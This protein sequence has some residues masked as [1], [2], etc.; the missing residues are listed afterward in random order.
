MEVEEWVVHSSVEPSNAVNAPADTHPPA[1][2]V[3]DEARKRAADDK[4]RES[5]LLELIKGPIRPFKE[6]S[7]REAAYF[8]ELREAE[9]VEESC[10][11]AKLEMRVEDTSMQSSENR[12]IP[13]T[14]TK[15]PLTQGRVPTALSCEAVRSVLS[16]SQSSRPSAID[17]SLHVLTPLL[18]N[19]TIPITRQGPEHFC[20]DAQESVASLCIIMVGLPARGKTFLAQRICR[21]LGWHGYRA[22]V[23]NIQVAWRR[24]LLEYKRCHSGYDAT[25]MLPVDDASFSAGFPPAKSE[26][27]P[28]QSKTPAC[29]NSGRD[30]G[31]T[32]EQNDISDTVVSSSP[33]PSLPMMGPSPKRDYVCAEQFRALICDP[34]SI[35]RR[36][37]RRVLERYALDAKSFYARGGDVLVVNDD[38]ITEELRDEAEALFSPLASQTFFMEVI[39]SNERNQKF[40]E[41]KL[42]DKS[43]YPHDVNA[44]EAQRDFARR[45]EYLTEVY[46]T[47]SSTSQSTGGPSEDEGTWGDVS[48]AKDKVSEK[49]TR[50]K[51]RE[52]R[53]MKLW[54]SVEIEVHG[55]TGYTASRIVSY[56]MNLTQDKIQHPIFFV[57]HGESIYNVENR[58][59]GDSVLSADGEKGANEI[60]GF[61]ASLKR[62]YCADTNKT[63]DGEGHVNNDDD[64]AGGFCSSDY[65]ARCEKSVNVEVWTSQLRRA[66][67][68]VENSELLLGIKNVRWSSLNE[69]H[70]GI[71]EDLTFE[72]VRTQHPLI[73]QFRKIN[74]Y[75]FR[76]P[77]GESYQDLVLRLEPVI[78][79]LENADR[80]VVV[81]AHQ[82]VLRT[83]LAYFGSTSAESCVRLELPHRTIWRCTYDSKGI[84]SLDEMKFG[85]Q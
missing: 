22:K 85:L 55:V 14:S 32:A 8:K 63:A 42:H 21:N 29:S 4:E 80:I 18:D 74:K 49:R 60:L 73:D 33:Q 50:R 24:L 52:R 48:C 69:I 66:I 83:L 1:T 71:C 59:G 39:R 38:F 67:Q 16:S 28:I 68:T 11:S 81:V 35:E 10:A 65:R 26:G 70:A 20:S 6:W 36:L 54:N 5:R 19:Y 41:L 15:C 53:Y 62:Y 34:D 37:Y 82:A 78:M 9:S 27:T 45:I 57:R 77:E 13:P 30:T 64:K 2:V 47:L 72:E 76:Y 84:S 3:A 56:V 40:N 58:I 12:S 79:E 61:L 44:S 46:S 7:W 23:L 17:S 75:T 43:E 31:I 25:N 51:Q